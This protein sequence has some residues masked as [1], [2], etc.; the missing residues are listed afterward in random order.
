MYMKKG[1]CRQQFLTA[2][3]TAPLSVLNS[4]LYCSSFVF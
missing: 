1:A 3:A 4:K 2:N